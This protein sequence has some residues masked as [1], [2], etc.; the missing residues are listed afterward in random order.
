MKKAAL[1]VLLVALALAASSV[2]ACPP[3]DRW[4]P[5]THHGP[6]LGF[7]GWWGQG[8]YGRFC[9]HLPLERERAQ[10]FLELKEKFVKE[11]APLREELLR[12]RIELQRALLSEKHEEAER[13]KR[14]LFAI[15]EKL[16]EKRLELEKEARQILGR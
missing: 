9:Y 7:K 12:K 14:E 2:F 15:K 5:R 3:Q 1:G 6:L 4:G 10:K 11:T 8:L 16:F 13:I